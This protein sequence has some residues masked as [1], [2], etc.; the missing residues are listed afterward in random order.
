[1]GAAK[2]EDA[3]ALASVVV[4]AL[5]LGLG[6]AA[7]VV[8][9]AP[10]VGTPVVSQ[11]GPAAIPSF[12]LAGGSEVPVTAGAR[13][14]DLF[15]VPPV[16]TIRDTI[17]RGATLASLLDAHD[18]GR[19]SVQLIDAVRAVFDPR[20]FRVGNPYRLQLDRDQDFVRRFEYHVDDESFLRVTRA[21]SDPDGQSGGRFTGALVPYKTERE[22]A[23]VRGTIDASNNSLVASIGAGGETVELAIALAE[24]LSGEIDFNNDLRRGDRFALLFERTWREGAFGEGET[25]FAGYGDILAAEFVNDG[26]EL[27]AYRFQVPGEPEPQYFDREGRSMKRLFLRSPFRFEPRVTSRFSYR[28]LHPVHGDVRPH[29]GV[30]YGAP[31]GTPVI[32]VATG[33]VVSAGRSGASGNMVRLR[34]TNG[35]ETYYLHLSAFANGIRPGVRVMQGQMIGR[36]GAT[37]VVTGP[38]LD[39]RMRKNGVFVNPLL[40][41]RNLPPG[42]PVPVGQ[43]A[44]FEELRDAA[45]QR[46][47]ASVAN[48]YGGGR[49]AP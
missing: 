45:G 34:H 27:R 47:R 25:V 7:F 10:L 29:L 6:A 18:V 22:E 38:H 26:R 23:T 28:R 12:D 9:G 35:Y 14:A 19:E 36:V 48:G 5:A 11:S 24:V 8:H 33:S 1:M 30:D 42:E 21:V 37:G 15:L 3:R 49:A 16:R 31:V 20:R 43:M 32:A 40:E 41:H 44:A 2:W 39:Y 46:L 17:G 13:D 4:V